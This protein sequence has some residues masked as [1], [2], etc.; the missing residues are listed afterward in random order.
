MVVARLLN[1]C[2]SCLF[3]HRV[4]SP[5]EALKIFLRLRG[6]A[7]VRQPAQYLVGMARNILG[8][9]RIDAIA[10]IGSRPPYAKTPAGR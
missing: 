3:F 1:P 5:M 7:S 10:P 8:S 6:R 2:A 9:L 4:L